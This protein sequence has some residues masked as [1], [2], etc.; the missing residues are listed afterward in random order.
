MDS[1]I[2][3]SVS[4]SVVLLLFD[5]FFLFEFF[6]QSGTCLGLRPKFCSLRKK[7]YLFFSNKTETV[8]GESADG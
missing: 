4:S 5:S 8:R 6:F 2:S 1:F 7:I 3:L